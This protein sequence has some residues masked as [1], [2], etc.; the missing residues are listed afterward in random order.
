MVYD[1]PQALRLSIWRDFAPAHP[2]AMQ[3][4]HAGW[5]VV[6]RSSGLQEEVYS[7]SSLQ[8]PFEGI[9]D[10]NVRADLREALL[11]RLDVVLPPT[12]RGIDVLSEFVERAER[13]I[14][15]GHAGPMP[16][17]TASVEDAAHTPSE[18]NPLLALVMH[19]K[20]LVRC[21]ED[22]PNMSVSVR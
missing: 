11:D 14:D 16:S 5:R 20:W 2:L 1:P 10:D 13:S 8:N 18:P 6:G 15:Q 22:R 9:D 7:W 21:F 17:N 3:D 19:L 12:E 4:E